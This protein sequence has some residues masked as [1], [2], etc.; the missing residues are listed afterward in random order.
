MAKSAW[1]PRIVKAVRGFRTRAADGWNSE[2]LHE[3][4]SVWK[5][6]EGEFRQALPADENM[7]LII[8][9]YLRARADRDWE[10]ARHY[11]NDIAWWQR[12]KCPDEDA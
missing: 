4:A 12:H 7:A 5:A 11:Y 9:G 10:S 2:N 6:R 8:S 1:H 3:A